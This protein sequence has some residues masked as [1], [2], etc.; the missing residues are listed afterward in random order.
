MQQPTIEQFTLKMD[1]N[2]NIISVNARG[3]RNVYAS[4]LTIDMLQTIMDLCHTDDLPVLEAHIN[5]VKQ[6]HMALSLPYRLRLGGPDK[7]VRVK[8][9][10]RLF[11]RQP[12]SEFI[13]SL[14][15]ILSDDEE[16]SLE[17]LS[18]NS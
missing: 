12:E 13:M 8:A 5:D 4:N 15:T 11:R 17:S 9:N 10:S 3:L 14:N 1:T 7:Y 16:L 2:G 6:S 18:I